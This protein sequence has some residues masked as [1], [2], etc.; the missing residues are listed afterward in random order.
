MA[1]N[2]VPSIKLFKIHCIKMTTKNIVMSRIYSNKIL[3][4]IAGIIKIGPGTQ[5]NKSPQNLVM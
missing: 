1:L 5:K 2:I 4:T 3:P